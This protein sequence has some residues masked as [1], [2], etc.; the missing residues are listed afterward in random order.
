LSGLEAATAGLQTYIIG[1]LAIEI[2]KNDG[3]SLCSHEAKQLIDDC[4]NTYAAFVQYWL[5]QSIQKPAAHPSAGPLA[6]T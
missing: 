4:K 6:N 5:K 2:G 3:K 1:R